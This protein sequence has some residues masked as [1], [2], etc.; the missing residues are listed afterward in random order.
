MVQN[1]SYPSPTSAQMGDG[2]FYTRQNQVPVAA[3][4]QV[5]PQMPPRAPQVAMVGR[6]GEVDENIQKAQIIQNAQNLRHP[7]MAQM[8]SLPTPEQLA[9]VGLESSQNYD[10]L[11]AESARK[12]TKVS[13]ACD[14]CRRKKVI[15]VNV[16]QD[17][18][19][20]AL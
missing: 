9:R 4:A 11:A 3:D 7:Q 12:R 14:E 13:R 20:V 17:F 8:A 15:I 2:P 10:H 1:T 16:M 18:P 5:S 19:N 6:D